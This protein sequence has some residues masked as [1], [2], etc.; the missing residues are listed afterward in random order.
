MRKCV[1]ALLLSSSFLLAQDSNPSATNHNSKDSKGQITVQGCV[2]RSSGDYILIK[3]DPAMTYELQA[4]GK[5]RLRQYL[6]QRVE[7]TGNESPSMST[8]SDAMTRWDRSL[9]DVDHHLDQDDREGMH[10]YASPDRGRF[11]S[12]GS[13]TLSRSPAALP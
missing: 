7:V 2:S 8:S 1:V 10:R 3:Q 11:D 5:I 4:T 9:G 13:G 6:G 12:H